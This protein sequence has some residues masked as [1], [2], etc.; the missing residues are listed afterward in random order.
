MNYCPS[1]DWDRYC[2]ADPPD[3]CPLCKAEEDTW[4]GEEEPRCSNCGINY[5][6]AHY[7]FNDLY[8]AIAS[9]IPQEPDIVPDYDPS[10]EELKEIEEA[11]RA[12]EEARLKEL[13]YLDENGQ[14]TDACYRESDF[15]YD[16]LR[17]RL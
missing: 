8:N 12:S 11:H 15:Q 3:I 13:G 17:E 6:F 5:N 4:V 10:P 2:E 14:P 9:T 7:H 16:R 1:Q